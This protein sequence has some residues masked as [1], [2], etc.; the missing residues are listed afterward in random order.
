[1]NKKVLL[2]LFVLLWLTVGCA[3][4]NNF[5]PSQEVEDSSDTPLA[6]TAVFSE[7]LAL[8]ATPD[9]A[10]P[11]TAVTQTRPTLRVWLPPEIALS[12]EEGAAILNAQLA[13]YRSNHPEIEIIIEQKSISGQ[14]GILNYLRTGRTVAPTILPDLIAIPIDQ[15]GSALSEELIYPLDGLVETSFLED[16]YP[17]ALELVLKESLISG[18][19]FVLTSLPH[20]AYNSEAVTTTIPTSWEP[21]ISLPNSFVFPANGLP[22]GTLALQLYMAAGGTLTNE[23]GQVALQSEPLITALQQLATA[24][25]NGFILDQSGNYSS[26]EETWQLF[27]AGTADFTITN[28]EQYLQLRDAE[29]VFKVTAVPGLQRPLT[30]LVSGWAWAMS[31]ADPTQRELAA[32]LLASLL[33]SDQLGEWSYASNFL[34]ARQTALDFWPADDIY[35]AFAKEQLNRASAMPVSSSNIMTALNNAV[36]DV[37]TQ[38]K[39]PQAAAEDAIAALQP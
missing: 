2:L 10:I 33:A 1:M 28:S 15:L 36:F 9:I 17:A 25:E 35:V 22:G 32:N 16:L 34:P 21:F 3:L 27:Q 6:E 19:P 20:L 29:A 31:T 4:V 30:P 8:A 39:T 11:A 38:A 13:A 12:T 14:S 37:V 18:Y 23:A 26:L 5:A 24:K 7:N